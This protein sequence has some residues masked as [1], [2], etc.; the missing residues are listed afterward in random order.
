MCGTGHAD[1]PIV[2]QQKDFNH[3]IPAYLVGHPT[4][5]NEALL[6]QFDAARH[7]SVMGW[8]EAAGA[9][10]ILKKEQRNCEEF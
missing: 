10:L 3:Y 6:L 7:N 2:R 5:C 4:F 8:F 9:C 1:A